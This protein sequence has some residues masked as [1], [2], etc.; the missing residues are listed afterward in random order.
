MRS[1]HL[2]YDVVI[3]WIVPFCISVANWQDDF[4]CPSINN[5]PLHTTSNACELLD[6]AAKRRT[7]Y[8]TQLYERVCAGG[9]EIGIL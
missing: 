5:E 7:G 8:T 6:A 3:L 2:E 4:S 1:S 9:V